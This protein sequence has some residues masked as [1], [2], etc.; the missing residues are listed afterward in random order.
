MKQKKGFVLAYTL[1]AMVIVFA[2]TSVLLSVIS[3][4]NVQA[5]KGAANFQNRV[6]ISQIANHFVG[7]KTDDFVLQYE[8][9]GFEKLVEGA[10]IVLHKEDFEYSIFLSKDAINSTLFVV[11]NKKNLI[12]ATVE[13]SGQNVV[14]WSYEVKE[15]Q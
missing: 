9:M 7:Q 15:N 8:N 4:Q 13:K 14:V 6:E 11:Q 12:V 5:K 1:V 10:K 3:M 2:L